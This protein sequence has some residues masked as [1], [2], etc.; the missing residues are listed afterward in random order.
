MSYIVGNDSVINLNVKQLSKEHCNLNNQNLTSLPDLPDDVEEL[1][2]SGNGLR[3]L[4][5]LPKFLT[6]LYCNSNHITLV[7]ILSNCLVILCCNYNYITELPELS[8]I[9]TLKE[10][11]CSNNRLTKLPALPKG[12]IKLFCGCNQLTELPDLPKSLKCL[13]C[14]HN[15]LTFLPNLPRLIFLASQHKL[16]GEKSIVSLTT[17]SLLDIV[18]RGLIINESDLQKIP[19]ELRELLATRKKCSKCL[20]QAILHISI[21]IEETKFGTFPIQHWLCCYCI[22]LG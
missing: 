4:H 21:K 3:D 15:H 18:S 12:L 6:K 13:S 11:D 1:D 14:F 20:A 5:N 16:F 22:H 8:E 10:L 2:C 19:I 7:P 9:N 17:L